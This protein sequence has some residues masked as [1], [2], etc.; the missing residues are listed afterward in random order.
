[1]FD[2]LPPLPPC[3]A[4]NHSAMAMDAVKTPH[5][6]QAIDNVS[7]VQSCSTLWTSPQGY[8]V[9]MTPAGP[10]VYRWIYRP[11]EE[12]TQFPMPTEGKRAKAAAS[13]QSRSEASWAR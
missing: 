9:I 6:P 7:T 11:A 1:M 10:I 8:Q 13:E 3:E 4:A 5:E 2:D 12:M